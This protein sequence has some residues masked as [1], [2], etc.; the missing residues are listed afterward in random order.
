[1]VNLNTVTSNSD[2]N[3]NNNKRSSLITR[4]NNK[5]KK[6]NAHVTNLLQIK[7]EKFCKLCN[8]SSNKKAYN[9][10]LKS[11]GHLKK[12]KE[13]AS[14]D[15]TQTMKSSGNNMEGGTSNNSERD[16]DHDSGA[17]NDNDTDDDDE[18]DILGPFT[19]RFRCFVESDDESDEG[20]VGDPDG[21]ANADF[22]TFQADYDGS[23]YPF[24]TL[25]TMILHAF[26][27]GDDEP[28]SQQTL[29][30]VLYLVELM[31]KLKGEAGTAP[32]ELPKL[33]ALLNF[34]IRKKNNVPTFKT[35]SV[36][37]EITKS[38]KPATTR[39]TDTSI[40]AAITTTTIK[41]IYYINL[42]SSI[43]RLLVDNPRKSP[44]ISALPDDT[45]NGATSLQQGS[46]WQQYHLFQQPVMTING[47][48]Y[49]V[50]DLVEVHDTGKTIC[51]LLD[52][53]Y[54]LNGTV[55]AQGYEVLMVSSNDSCPSFCIVQSRGFS[56]QISNIRA[57]LSKQPL[58][59]LQC[60]S[61]TPDGSGFMQLFE[62][63]QELING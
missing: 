49:W 57:I 39:A 28:V 30:K 4:Q 21:A 48:D 29:K 20:T 16:E 10:H 47:M 33:D 12:V 9:G 8:S 2:N 54:L 1:M 36:E 3:S 53:Y 51:L 17:D 13:S 35:S 31:V 7:T 32:F 59:Q 19:T 38:Q 52:R 15:D 34:N 45:P 22:A 63:H 27:H 26:I 56:T 11:K 55:M 44:Y 43:L 23:T 60:V 24:K 42:P 62:R 61:Q 14:M 41:E 50:G 6:T 18:E 58:K 5:I 40:D 25:Q 37:V 46:K